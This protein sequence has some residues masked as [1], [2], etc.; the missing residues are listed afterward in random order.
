MKNELDWNIA[1]YCLNEEKRLRGCLD[2]VLAAIGGC[3]ALVTVILNGSQDGS[4]E[5][6]KSFV[7]AGHP[8]ELFRIT[9]GDKAN[10][11]NQFNYHLR[12]PARAYGGVDGYVQVAPTSFRAMGERLATDPDAM[13]ATGICTNGRTMRLAT[14]A[15][16]T[17][18]GQL[19]GQLHSFRRDFIDR[20]VAS[21]IKLPLGIYWGDGL[22][23][24]MAA[25][26]LDALG[27]PW[28]SRRIAG[29]AAATYEIPTLSVLRPRDLRQQFRR[30]IRQQRGRIQNAAIKD[31]IYRLGYKG[32]PEDADMMVLDYLA[33]H[34]P[35]K[36]GWPDRWFQRIALDQARHPSTPADL[37]PH[38][39]TLQ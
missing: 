8:I 39:V 24:S 7:A 30:R 34:R 15:T 27:K 13:A 1:V 9:A 31:L 12:S 4:A 3:N 17:V 5:I 2:S 14:K 37:L 33:S 32:L 22:L 18:G 25:H 23:G 10:A 21:G 36:A 11:I 6:A 38:A 29:V 26:D 28:E 16:L 35:P 20:M 19:H